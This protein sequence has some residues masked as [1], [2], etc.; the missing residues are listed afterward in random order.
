VSNEASAAKL[1][2]IRT[3]LEEGWSLNQLK[4]TYGITWATVN[5]YFP[6][7][8]R[9][10]KNEGGLIAAA[11]RRAVYKVGRFTDG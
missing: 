3:R 5:K 11:H 6:D 10:S 4:K 1:E 2:L 9:M 7:R 8:Q